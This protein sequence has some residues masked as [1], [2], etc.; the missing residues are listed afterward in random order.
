MSANNPVIKMGATCNSRNTFKFPILKVL[1]VLYVAPIFITGISADCPRYIKR[2]I[3]APSRITRRGD[4]SHTS[5]TD[6]RVTPNFVQNARKY[7]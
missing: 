5:L 4:M 7:A 2:R 1:R 3:C 6:S